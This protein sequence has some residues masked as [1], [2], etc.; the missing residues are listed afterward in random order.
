ML[1][2]KL[3]GP[4]FIE[5]LRNGQVL[6]RLVNKLKP[7]TIKKVNVM[8]MPF[9]HRENIANYIAAAAETFGVPSHDSFVTVDLY[10][11]KDPGQVVQGCRW[12]HLDEHPFGGIEQVTGEPFGSLLHPSVDGIQL[13]CELHGATGSHRLHSTSVRRRST[14]PSELSLS[15][16]SDTLIVPPAP[17]R[18]V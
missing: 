8:K 17:P 15:Q 4:D 1:G 7:G 11:K 3:Q 2:E 13:V 6:C 16:V 9:A 5:E 10:E 12:T 14:R 18:H